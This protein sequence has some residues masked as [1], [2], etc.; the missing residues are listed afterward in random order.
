MWQ[1]RYWDPSDP[2]RRYEKSFRNKGAADRWLTQQGASVLTGTHVDPRR[3]DRPFREIADAWAETW[4]DLEPKTKE[5]YRTALDCHLLPEFGSRK[6]SSLSPELVQR[7]VNRMSR[8]GYAAGTVRGTY[9]VL[10]NSL[11]TGVRLKMLAVNPCTGVKLPRQSKEEMLFLSQDEIR[12]LAEGITPH[13]RLLIYTAAYT[14]LRSGELRGLR[15]KRVDLLRG[16]LLVAEALKE[17]NGKKLAPE[18]K[19]LIFGPTK[20]HTER[21]VVLPRFLRDMLNDHLTAPSPGGT[22][23]DDLVFVSKTGTPIRQHL[24][25]R[26]HFK[27]A[28]R[29]ALPARL[30]GL[31]FHDLRHTCVALLISQGAHA[32]TI[33]QHMGHADIGTTMNRYGHVFPSEHD[34]LAD[35]L[36]AAF[37]ESATLPENVEALRPDERQAARSN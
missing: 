30:R 26:R 35:R 32:K 28:V 37:A 3:G 27:P 14:G 16:R 25:Y 24:F 12:A 5:A 21:T 31:R 20:T 34:S 4:V 9:A 17:I 10:R 36:D 7:F 18:D 19:G 2:S 11:N 15:R 22:G 13:Y 29:A 8:D 23:P 33:Q 1:A 6:V